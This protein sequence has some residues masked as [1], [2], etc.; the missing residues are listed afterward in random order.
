VPISSKAARFIRAYR[1]DFVQYADILFFSAVNQSH[2]EKLVESFIRTNQKLIVIA[3]M[4]H[5][6]CALGSSDGVR[7]FEPVAMDKPIVDTNGAGDGLAVGFLSSFVLDKYPLTD[8][9]Q[10]GQIVARHTCTLKASSSTLITPEELDC[11]FAGRGPSV[12]HN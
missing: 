10:R 5:K 11:Y 3:G 9:V 6:G 2:P 8:A 7:F 1:R 4:G 12:P